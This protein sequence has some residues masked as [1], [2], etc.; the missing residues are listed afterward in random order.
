MPR[1]KQSGRRFSTVP[2]APDSEEA[3]AAHYQLLRAQAAAKTS[4][5]AGTRERELLETIEDLVRQFAHGITLNGAPAYW[6]GG[7]SALEGAFAALGW[8]DPHVVLGAEFCA[9]VGCDRWVFLA[10]PNDDGLCGN[11]QIAERRR[12]DAASEETN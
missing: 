4:A 1:R 2:F 6:T 10:H 9:V 5:L 11:H 12:Q 8:D 3:E 7:L